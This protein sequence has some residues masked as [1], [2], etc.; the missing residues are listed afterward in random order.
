MGVGKRAMIAAW[1]KRMGIER[2]TVNDDLTV[3][4]DGG[5]WLA[6]KGLAEF[7]SY[8]RFGSVSRDFYCH[9]NPLTSLVGCPERV[10]GSF[11]C[12]DSHLT[13][14]AGCPE[15]VEGSFSC[16]HNELSSLDGCP[17]WVGSNFYCGHNV[18]RFTK[19]EVKNLCD[20]GEQIFVT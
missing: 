17:K 9:N 14:L 3:D 18:R 16:S 12:S 15:T 5:V 4:V 10:G 2:Y 8:V 11:H 20:V 19:E 6:S 1:L 13:S 7:P